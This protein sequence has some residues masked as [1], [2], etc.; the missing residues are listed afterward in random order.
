MKTRRL[1]LLIALFVLTALS[2]APAASADP[3]KTEFSLRWGYFLD[4]QACG[5]GLSVT[6]NAAHIGCEYYKVEVYDAGTGEYFGTLEFQF[7][8]TN[9]AVYVPEWDWWLH[10]NFSGWMRIQPSGVAGYWEGNLASVGNDAMEWYVPISKGQLRGYGALAG[11]LMKTDHFF[12][13]C[14]DGT[15]PYGDFWPA[16]DGVIIQT[17]KK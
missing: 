1:T 10:Q 11:T 14:S 7:D 17:G 5:D 8:H 15:S 16:N 3:P 6:G 13:P 9:M 4:Y 2:L 12:E